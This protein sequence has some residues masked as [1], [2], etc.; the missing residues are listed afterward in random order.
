MDF[1]IVYNKIILIEQGIKKIKDRIE[2]NMKDEELLFNYKLGNF[3]HFDK[4]I[5]RLELHSVIW[6]SAKTYFDLKKHIIYDFNIEMNFSEYIETICGI[7]KKVEN[8]KE[9]A[10]KDGIEIVPKHSKLVKDDLIRLREF[11]IAI[12]GILHSEE[13]SE[14]LT[15]K[16]V[17]LLES[18]KLDTSLRQILSYVLRL[19]KIKIQKKP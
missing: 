5:A 17:L 19:K 13:L 4:S 10:V 16:I 18:R 14:E 3:E 12:N 9:L 2:I 6:K 8:N 15:H 1:D 11:L 7:E